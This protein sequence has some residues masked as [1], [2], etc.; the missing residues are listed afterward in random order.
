MAS[1][2]AKRVGQVAGSIDG[3]INGSGH[4]IGWNGKTALCQPNGRNQSFQRGRFAC[5][6][7]T[8]EDG[9]VSFRQIPIVLLGILDERMAEALD[10]ASA[11]I[12]KNRSAAISSFLRDESGCPANVEQVDACQ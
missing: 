10:A 1:S 11:R 6:V 2:V 9:D 12:M 3:D 7:R 5:H 4:G 8:G